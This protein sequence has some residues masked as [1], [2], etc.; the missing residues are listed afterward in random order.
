MAV[1]RR[2]T[3]VTPSEE[4]RLPPLDEVLSIS[5]GQSQEETEQPLSH[6]ATIFEQL[7]LRHYV[8]LDLRFFIPLLP[9]GE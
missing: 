2:V 9:T 1:S 7:V 6:H 3:I 8:L 5:S 4:R